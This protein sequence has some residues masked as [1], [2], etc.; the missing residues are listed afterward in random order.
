[1]QYHAFPAEQFRGN[2][3]NKEKARRNTVETKGMGTIHVYLILL[4]LCDNGIL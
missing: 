2:I 1:M 3:Q 4:F